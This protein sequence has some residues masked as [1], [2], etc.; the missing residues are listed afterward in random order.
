MSY[1]LISTFMNDKLN[2]LKQHVFINLNRQIHQDVSYENKVWHFG[3]FHR[4]EDTYCYKQQWPHVR[5][6]A[7]TG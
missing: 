2:C 1:Y 3:S 4:R 7:T 6:Y 5:I